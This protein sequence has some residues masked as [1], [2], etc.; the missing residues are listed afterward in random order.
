MKNIKLYLFICL[1]FSFI[2]LFPS[3]VNAIS[4]E[5]DFVE[6]ASINDTE[7]END[8]FNFLVHYDSGIQANALVVIGS[9]IGKNPQF[10][11]YHYIF[12]FYDN[13]KQEIFDING[14]GWTEDISINPKGIETNNYMYHKDYTNNEYLYYNDESPVKYYKLYIEPST[15]ENA[16][17]YIVA[18]NEQRKLDKEYPRT[19]SNTLPLMV[20]SNTS[21]KLNAPIIN[22]SGYTNNNVNN[23]QKIELTRENN[24]ILKILLFAIPLAFS[25]ISL[26]LWLKY[27]K[28]N[29]VF[30]TIEYYPPEGFNSAEIGFLYKGKAYES[31]VCSLLIHLANKGYLRIDEVTQGNGIVSYLKMFNLI[32]LKEYNEKNSEE[33]FFFNELFENGKIE[34]IHY[35]LYNKF[36]KTIDGILSNMN[37]KEKINNVIE[38]SSLKAKVLIIIMVIITSFM[39]IIIPTIL[40]SNINSLTSSVFVTLL[41]IPFY[42]FVFMKKISIY[43][44]IIMGGFLVFH[45]FGMFSSLPL[46]EAITNDYVLLMGFIFGLVSTLFMIFCSKISPKRTA[47]GNEIY[48]KIISFRSFILKADK[49]KLEELAM[50]NPMYFYD[51][52]PYAYALGLLNKWINNFKGINLQPPIWHNNDSSFD[53][54]NVKNYVKRVISSTTN[55][56]TSKPSRD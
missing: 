51:M 21:S 40:Y 41:Y 30:K 13:N 53:L 15:Y 54:L 47:Y 29:K 1:L 16:S 43:F 5:S 12:T 44:R 49:L 35:N 14:H 18:K 26:I 2:I 34:I 37:T 52:I 6:L 22:A 9:F 38:K 7:F 8:D 28:D 3:N 48:G 27:G 55:A 19:D 36:Y 56:M 20:K 23:D 10:Y 45:S 50:Q 17:E 46:K 39:T 33:R 25:V 24:Y 42:S 4:Y 11:Y 31:D 32:K